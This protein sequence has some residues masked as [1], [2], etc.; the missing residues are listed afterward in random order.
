MTPCPKRELIHVVPLWG[1]EHDASTACWCHPIPE[2]MES[3]VIVHREPEE[4]TH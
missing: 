1:P 4:A 3:Y 2:E